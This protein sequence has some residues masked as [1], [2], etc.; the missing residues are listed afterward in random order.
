MLVSAVHCI[1]TDLDCSVNL[2]NTLTGRFM[3]I[4]ILC[5]KFMPLNTTMG[6]VVNW[7]L[8]IKNINILKY[9]PQMYT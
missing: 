6:G 4:V 8:C 2:S 3:F 9:T 5:L 7:L 1:L